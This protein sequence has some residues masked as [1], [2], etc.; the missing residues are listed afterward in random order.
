MFIHS[1][2]R[3]ALRD[4][5]SDCGSRSVAG[6]STHNEGESMVKAEPV[7]SRAYKHSSRRASLLIAILTMLLTSLLGYG[8]PAYAGSNYTTTCNTT[9]YSCD[10][11]G[12]T[13][14]STWTFPGVHNCTNYAAWRLSVSGMA[15]PGYYL[16]DASNWAKA[17]QAN[18]VRVDA[19]PAVGSIAQWNAYTSWANDKYGHVGY[20]AA[21]TSSSITVV[22]DNYPFTAGNGVYYAGHM[23]TEVFP[24]GSP[25][26]PSHFIH[27]NDVQTASNSSVPTAPIQ[28]RI[29][30]NGDGK[31]DL[32]YVYQPGNAVVTFLSL[33]NGQF[34]EQPAFSLRNGF[35]STHGTWM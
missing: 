27:F 6:L 5:A 18:G 35:D 28:F 19:I 21:V 23:D 34:T 20:V 9:G 11:T 33:G 7:G 24:L 32:V 4:N 31:T 2:S 12:Y 10:G 8:V 29:D 16:G 15:K 30:V 25:D 1:T 3:L 13:G 22:A 17:A 14:Q 26:W